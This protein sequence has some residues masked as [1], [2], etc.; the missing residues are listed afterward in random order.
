MNLVIVGFVLG[1]VGYVI[2]FQPK[3]TKGKRS[4][5]PSCF[6]VFCHFYVAHDDPG[7]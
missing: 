1:F 6:P 4:S 3:V 5:Y 7:E 2:G